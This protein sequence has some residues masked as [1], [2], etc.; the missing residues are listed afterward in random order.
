MVKCLPLLIFFFV[1]SVSGS[2]EN[3]LIFGS[4]TYHYINYADAGR[5]FANKETEDGRLISNPTV[6][7]S[8]RTLNNADFNTDSFFVM[9]DSIGSN[10]FGYLKTFGQ[11]NDYNFYFGLIVG[12]YLIRNKKW[13]EAGLK[14]PLRWSVS[15][16]L[17]LI[18]I[19][20]MQI[21]KRFDLTTDYFIKFNNILTVYITNHS[22]SIGKSF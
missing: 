17:G 10:A 14:P 6:G 12:G 22:F 1:F 16:S 5:T 11:K 21:S 13:E 8:H 3:E 19:I 7:F 2:E 4:L 15:N 18:P 9:E 20:G